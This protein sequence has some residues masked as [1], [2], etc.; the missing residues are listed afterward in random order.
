MRLFPGMNPLVVVEDSF[1][2]KCFAARFADV[3]SHTG[4]KSCVRLQRKGRLQTATTVSTYENRLFPS[5]MQLHVTPKTR[6]ASQYLATVRAL[7]VL[8]FRVFNT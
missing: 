3:R 4:M 2:S 5:G 7:P 6:L 8:A 1:G